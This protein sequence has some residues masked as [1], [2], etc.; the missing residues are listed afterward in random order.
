MSAFVGIS[1]YFKLKMENLERAKLIETSG[2]KF[3][4]NLIKTKDLDLPFTEH[5]DEL[6]QR[7]LQLLIILVSI[8]CLV[9]ID[10]KAVVQLLEIPVKDV[11]FFQLSPGEYFL[12]TIKIASYS[13]ILLA[14]PA[15][16]S[17]IIFFI[18][19]GI[20]AQEKKIILPILIGS[21]ILFIGGL[22]FSYYVLI[23]AALNFFY[24]I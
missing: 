21:T 12:S 14:S 16:L 3:K 17:Q 11:R 22:F 20:S 2:F 1:F 5:I 19:P 6:Q 10:V 15:L 24:K 4:S 18:L 9:F 7:S 13:G 8:I 23:P